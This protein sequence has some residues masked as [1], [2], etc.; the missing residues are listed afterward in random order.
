M[1]KAHGATKTGDNLGRSWRVSLVCGEGLVDQI[2]FYV[3][4]WMSPARGMQPGHSPQEV[5]V[6]GTCV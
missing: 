1:A 4:L 2:G 5:S 3:S 6:A